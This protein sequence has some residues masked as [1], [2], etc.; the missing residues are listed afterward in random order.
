MRA[1]LSLIKVECVDPGWTFLEHPV[2]C[3]AALST[4]ARAVLAGRLKMQD[5]EN[6]GPGK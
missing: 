4:L 5:L 2:Q 3:P 6:A 1:Q